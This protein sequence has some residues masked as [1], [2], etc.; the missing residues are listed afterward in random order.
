MTAVSTGFAMTGPM[1]APA[2]TTELGMARLC[3]GNQEWATCIARA[4]V[5]PSAKPSSTRQRT[6]TVKPTCAVIGAR[7]SAHSPAMPHEQPARPDLATEPSAEDAA[8][9]EQ[10]EEAALDNAE[11]GVVQ[12]QFLLHPDACQAHDDLVGVVDDH[13]THKQRDHDPR[14]AF[15]RRVGHPHPVRRNGTGRF[16]L[17]NSHEDLLGTDIDV[18]AK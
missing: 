11:L 5:G 8:D 14:S 18:A 12:T 3:A 6:T 9:G 13:Q 1:P 17:I 15:H 7:V 2:T 4:A 10:P 16:L